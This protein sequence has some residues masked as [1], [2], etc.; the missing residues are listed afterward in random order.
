[1]T[2]S[3]ASIALLVVATIILC[4]NVV[5]RFRFNSKYRLPPEIPGWPIIGNTLD[6]P[7][8]GGVWGHEMAK[9]YG[10]MYARPLLDTMPRVLISSNAPRRL[11][12]LVALAAKRWFF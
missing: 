12:S 3:S 9:K 5:S 1:M 10:E 11:G 2:L 8:P 6:V 4:K 7:F